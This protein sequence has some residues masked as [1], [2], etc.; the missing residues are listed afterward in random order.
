MMIEYRLKSILRLL[1]FLSCLFVCVLANGE[2][3]V[4]E[5]SSKK[6]PEWVMHHPEGYLVAIASAPTLQDA[7][8]RVE[9]ELLRKV[10]SAIAVN[11][12]GQTLTDSGVEEGK[13]WDNFYSKLSVRSAQLPFV[14]DISL[15]K[16]KDTYWEHSFDK[17]SGKDNYDIYVLYPFDAA[18]RHNLI[19]EYEAYDSK[20]ENSLLQLE[21]EYQNADRYEDILKFEGELEGLME[22]FPDLQRRKRAEK[23]LEAYKKIKTSLTLVGIIVAKGECCVRVMRGDKIFKV[24]GRLDASSNCAS[25]I[26]IRPES[27]GWRIT[28]NTD[29]CLEDE[30][31][32]LKITLRGAG[33]GLK[34]T[35]S[36]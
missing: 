13:E 29:D 27:D 30:D 20:M 26:V 23:T 10:M 4:V 2:M 15:A 3:K 18:T 19:V 21:N 9:Q 28:F 22:W 8:S 32:D 24:P 16:S 6:A 11:V 35:V 12:E 17:A 33:M 34:T 1:S 31:N 25:K 36:L 7:Q 14:S 5:R